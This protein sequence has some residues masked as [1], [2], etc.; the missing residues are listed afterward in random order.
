MA[1]HSTQPTKANYKNQ[2]YNQIN[3]TVM[4]AVCLQYSGDFNS[5]QAR[6]VSA[7]P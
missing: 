1:Y 6:A 4:K 5:F 3:A 2:F 7:P